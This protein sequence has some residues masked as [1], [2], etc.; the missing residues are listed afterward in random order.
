MLFLSVMG[1][2]L[3][4][5]LSRYDKITLPVMSPSSRLKPGW[6]QRARNCNGSLSNLKTMEI[7]SMNIEC[8]F[9]LKTI[10]IQSSIHLESHLN[11][12]SSHK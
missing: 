12:L 6:L 1:L 11:I 9:S 3:P 4:S 7:P 5:S 2:V 8:Y 10:R